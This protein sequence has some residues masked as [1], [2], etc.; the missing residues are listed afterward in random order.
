MAYRSPCILDNKEFVIPLEILCPAPSLLGLYCSEHLKNVPVCLKRVIII[1]LLFLFYRGGVVGSLIIIYG[2][3][4]D[5]TEII[6]LNQ[7]V[8]TIIIYLQIQE[9]KVLTK[10]TSLFWLLM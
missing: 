2:N 10:S 8:C 6:H 5:N 1:Y 3:A 9:S 7:K 4:N